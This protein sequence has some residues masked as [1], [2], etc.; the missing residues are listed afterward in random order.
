MKYYK[1]DDVLP[2]MLIA[3]LIG[4][5]V[6]LALHHKN[7]TAALRRDIAARDMVIDSTSRNIERALVVMR[8]DAAVIKLQ[9]KRIEGYKTILR[10]MPVQEFRNQKGERI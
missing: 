6:V 8:A 9:G 2:T 1:D 3:M 7:E 4:L 5:V 10:A